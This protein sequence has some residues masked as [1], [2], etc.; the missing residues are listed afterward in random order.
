MTTFAPH[1]SALPALPPVDRFTLGRSVALVHDLA[2]AGGEL[3]P[4][5]GACDV[6]YTEMA[7]RPG[8]ATFLK[9]AGAAES[10]FKSYMGA[11][12]A[13]AE[14]MTVPVYIVTGRSLERYFP[15]PDQR[16]SALF[17]DA[18]HKGGRCV[19]LVYR[20]EFTG[21]ERITL[22][23]CGALPDRFRCVGD[24][25]CGYGN[26]GRVFAER[27]GDFVLSDF[28]PRCIAHVAASAP[29]WRR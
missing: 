21:P 3:P 5:Y 8:Y 7:W 22:D 23:I 20:D 15:V 1:H 24:P 27:G 6:I 28:N 26:S 12:A 4:E 16:L 19:V 13:M 25:C 29:G 17:P 11:L 14:R 10:S 9:R 2:A 18:L